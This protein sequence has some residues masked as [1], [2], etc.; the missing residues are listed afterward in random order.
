MKTISKIKP[1]VLFIRVTENCNAGCFMC[2]FAKSKKQLYVTDKSMKNIVTQAKK[3]GIRLVRFTGGEPLLHQGITSFIGLFK[4]QGIKTSIITN[5]FLLPIRLNDLIKSGLDQ[6]IIS[7]DGSCSSIHDKLR[8]LPGAFENVIKSIKSIKNQKSNLLIRVNTVVSPFNFE[9][10]ENILDLL[11][12]LGVDQWSIIPLKS[13]ENLWKDVDRSKIL[14]VYRRF[15]DKA[16]N[17]T[18]PRLLG[19]SKQWAGRNNLEI[20]KYLNSG[21]TFSPKGKCALVDLVRFY[22]PFTDRLLPCNCVP[23]RLKNVS[24]NTEC[25]LAALTDDALSPFVEYLKTNGSALCLGCEPINSYLAEH[26]EIIK[27]DIFAI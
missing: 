8:N 18:L 19:Y 9:D 23:W 25:G 12:S 7:L 17:L 1:H 16:D 2:G 5:G 26:P 13:K 14:S 3:A 22:I 24:F 20:D 27:D 4:S 15:Q 10:L 21:V 11:V 6:V